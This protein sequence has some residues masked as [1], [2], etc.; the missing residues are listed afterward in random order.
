MHA[1]QWAMRQKTT[2]RATIRIAL[3]AAITSSDLKTRKIR[4]RRE[5]L[6]E[7]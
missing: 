5:D 2:T 6:E 4:R 3:A 7:A 1:N